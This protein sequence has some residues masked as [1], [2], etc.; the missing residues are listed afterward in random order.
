MT[1]SEQSPDLRVVHFDNEPDELEFIPDAMYEHF[2]R[3]NGNG[4]KIEQRQFDDDAR[5]FV[6]TQKDQ[7][8]ISYKFVMY[9]NVLLKSLKDHPADIVILDVRDDKND[10]IGLDVFD[11]LTSRMFKDERSKQGNTLFF[12]AYRDD[13]DQLVSQN[14]IEES[15][16]FLKPPTNRFFDSLYALLSRRM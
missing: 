14:Q 1:P 15:H 8:S 4:C 2:M 13:L 16:I 6:L 9:R 10:P 3:E 7:P 12:T 5:E 11:S